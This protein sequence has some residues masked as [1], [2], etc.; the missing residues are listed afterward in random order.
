MTMHVRNISSVSWPAD[1]GPRPAAAANGIRAPPHL[2]GRHPH[3]LCLNH[4]SVRS[5]GTPA[6]LVE[7]SA[8][9]ARPYART[10]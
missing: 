3:Q 4:A 7:E 9:Q 2:R 1:I 10:P 5:K 6:T 8:V